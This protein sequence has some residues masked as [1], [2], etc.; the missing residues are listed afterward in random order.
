[1]ALYTTLKLKS[2]SSA[3]VMIDFTSVI[4][5][6]LRQSVIIRYILYTAI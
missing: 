2:V 1:M 5:E 4:G 6:K 3:L